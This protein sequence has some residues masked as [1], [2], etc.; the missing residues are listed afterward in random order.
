MTGVGSL[1]VDTIKFDLLQSIVGDGIPYKQDMKVLS[2]T[3]PHKQ[4]LA[5]NLC[6]A[7]PEGWNLLAICEA[8]VPKCSCVYPPP[9]KTSSR[10]MAV[11]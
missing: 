8:S 9:K 5:Q 7:R 4:T 11:P 3:E 2:G 6:A 10:V 1:T